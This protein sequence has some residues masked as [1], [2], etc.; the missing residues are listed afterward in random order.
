M[1]A[2]DLKEFISR[3]EDYFSLVFILVLLYSLSSVIPLPSECLRGSLTSTY[4]Y[5]T[6]APQYQCNTNV[7]HHPAQ[8]L[9][10]ECC[11]IVAN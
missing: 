7:L 1:Q 6:T 3:T 9:G 11:G 10:V 2:F 8:K 5:S 4:P